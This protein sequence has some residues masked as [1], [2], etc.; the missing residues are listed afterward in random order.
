MAKATQLPSGSWRIRV[1][2]NELKKQISFTSDTPG[3]AGKAEVELMARE[4]QLGR[5]KKKE[6]GKTIGE[7]IDE[8]IEMKEHV[9]SPTTIDV[10]RRMKRGS[11]SDLCDI[12]VGKI[13]AADIQ[14]HVNKLSL[15][16]SPKTIRNAHGL[17]ASVLSIYA[18]ELRLNTTLPKVQKRI[19]QLP[20][21]QDVMKVII[22]TEIELPCLLAMW[23][24]LRISEIRGA[25]KRHIR[26]GVLTV[27]DTIVTAERETIEKHSTKTIESTRQIRLPKRILQLIDALPP[28]QEYLTTLSAHALYQRFT[29]LLDANGVQHMSFHDLRHMNASVMLALNIPDKYAME[30]GGWSTDHVMKT[31][32]QH[33]FSAERQAADDKIDTYFESV[34]DKILDTVND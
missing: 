5:K 29:K 25:K 9:L 18:P 17:L 11:L 28:D 26:D 2:D 4:Y 13:T 12:Y 6:V 32:Y 34:I 31:V 16:K 23:C 7:C 14:Q 8:Y 3:K 19:K 22:D 30:R 33:T 27:Q 15:T 10:Y 21:V 24:S 20:P 1:Y